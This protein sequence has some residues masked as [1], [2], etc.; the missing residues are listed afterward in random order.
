MV[1][2]PEFDTDERAAILE[3]LPLRDIAEADAA[4]AHIGRILGEMQAQASREPDANAAHSQ[5]AD[6]AK[7]SSQ[8]HLALGHLGQIARALLV[9]QAGRTGFDSSEVSRTLLWLSTWAHWAGVEIEPT[10][11]RPEAWAA[12]FAISEL[13]DLWEARTGKRATWANADEDGG[14]FARFVQVAIPALSL[15]QIRTVLQ[16]R[17]RKAEK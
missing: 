2:E 4:L 13:A 1:P 12:R 3:H 9:E 10:R 8:A 11:G 14:R 5:L 7:R 16:A 17:A 6:L 15:R